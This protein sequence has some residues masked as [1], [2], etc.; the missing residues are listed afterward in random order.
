MRRDQFFS[1][2][3]LLLFA[4]VLGA[5]ELP[6]DKSPAAS[7]KSITTRPWMTV[8]L[9]VAEPLIADPVAFDWGPDGSLWVAEMGDYPNGATWHKPGDPLGEPG[10]RIKRLT[11]TDGDGKYD[12][13]SL[14]LDTVPFP[15]GVKAWRGGVLISAA[16]SVFYAED[17]DGDGVADKREPLYEG[18]AEGNQQ[19]RVNGLR[20]GLDN[21]LHLA[22][23]DSG[24]T[25]KSVK[26]GTTIDIRGRDLRIR[27]DTG[28]IEAIAGQTQFGRN[29]DDWGNWFGGNNSNPMWHYVL[30]DVQLRR[31]PHFAPPSVRQPI[32]N[33]P[34]AAPVFPTSRTL[35]RFN[36]FDKTDRFTSACSPIIYRD[37]LL[38]DRR[39]AHA[40]ICEPVH[41]L[42]HREAV[43]QDGATFSSRR[44]ADEQDSEFLASADN[45]FRPTMV[46]TGPDGAVWVADMY[47][48]VIEHPEWIPMS[49]QQRLDLRSGHDQG[50]IYR[51]YPKV[52][53]PRTIPKLQELDTAGLVGALRSSN[54]WIRDSAQQMLVWENDQTAVPLL[55]ELAQSD[56]DPL[57]RLHALCTLDGMGELETAVLA[58]GLRADHPGLR[59][60][61]V[62]LAESQLND[63]PGLAELVVKAASDEDGLLRVQAAYALGNLK[64]P[65]AEEAL[66]KLLEGT[67]DDRYVR[68]AAMSSLSESNI[69]NVIREIAARETVNGELLSVLL[70][71]AT[72]YDKSEVLAEGLRP[73]LTPQDDKYAIWQIRAITTVMEAAVR[74]RQKPAEVFRGHEDSFATVARLTKAM[75]TDEKADEADRIACV[76]LLGLL[77]SDSDDLEPV[78]S[79][80]DPRQ[81]PALQEAAVA[82]LAARLNPDVP[83]QLLAAWHAHTPRLR[84]QILDSLLSR[85]SWTMELLKALD[86]GTISPSAF[87][88]RQR[89][90]LLQHP[91]ELVRS[92]AAKV[93]VMPSDATRAEVLKKYEHVVKAAGNVERGKAVFKRICSA[94]HRLDGVGKEIGPELTALTDK[95]PQALLAAI[96]DPNRA[97][98]DKYRTYAV[99]TQEGRS[100]TGMILEETANS[101]RLAAADG[102]EHVILRTDLDEMAATR[103]SLMPAGMEQELKGPDLADVIAYIRGIS[104]PPKTFP[105]NTPQVAPVRDDGSIRCLAMH[106]RVYGPKL[107]FEEKYRNLGF[108]GDAKDHAIWSLEVPKAGRYRVTLDYA[109]ANG[110]E[111]NGFVLATA[112]Q[113]LRGVVAGTGTWDDY[114][115]TNIGEIELPAGPTELT[116]RS[117]GQPRQFLLDLRTIRLTPVQ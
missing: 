69:A 98:E 53:Q 49:W 46:R 90:T 40:F 6:S 114:R 76:R 85:T 26:T 113:T 72:A 20:W 116:F 62:R 106:A 59:R 81:S 61:A 31:N 92:S 3:M 56:G 73:L 91:V 37:D 51:V 12:Q 83:R 104:S 115:S 13:V 108:W 111:G 107:V 41:N 30:D 52:S 28:E 25:I 7:L 32:S 97:V 14:F 67:P 88:A 11:D 117:D 39:S 77:A 100:F 75:A 99:L 110:T 89:Q 84:I 93:F 78:R 82:A 74:R 87:N 94:C 45:W 47:R 63:S 23:G 103:V 60:H 34:G 96:L 16:P 43:T 54:G 15:T 79:L 109:C 38:F 102:K 17:T 9:V 95:S 68:A 2:S 66:A 27:P 112:G 44:A 21:W 8:E 64:G 10:G 22:N 35:A 65:A 55:R 80:L 101:I 71:M 19:H 48:L 4:A 57:A 70:T 5:Q 105:G 18:F 50:R 24:G 42:V 36:D 1:L 58:S 29:R 33:Q 86:K